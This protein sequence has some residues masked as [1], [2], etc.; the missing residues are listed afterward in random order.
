MIERG[1]AY[2]DAHYAEPL[3]ITVVAEAAASSPS[4]FS[5]MFHESTGLTW[6]EYLVWVPGSTRSASCFGITDRGAPSG[7][8][9]RWAG[10]DAVCSGGSGG[11]WG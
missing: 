3:T 9:E 7:W 11:G 6:Q 2:T 5:R 4:H 1:I 10:R 8:H